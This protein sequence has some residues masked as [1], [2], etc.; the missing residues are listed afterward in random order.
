MALDHY[1]G[2][3][4]CNAGDGAR[5]SAHYDRTAIHVVANPPANVMGNM[6]ACLIGE[7]GTEVA[8]RPLDV[9]IDRGGQTDA[10]V[11][12][13]IGVKNLYFFP[14]FTQCSKLSIRLTNA[15]FS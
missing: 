7:P 10:D 5:I 12:T 8:G 3:T 15:Q 14:G 9:D 13:G 4:D 1:R 11:M 2:T 6:K